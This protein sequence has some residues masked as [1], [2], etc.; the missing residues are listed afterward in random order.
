MYGGPGAS[1]ARI[2]LGKAFGIA[3]ASEGGITSLG[4][5]ACA[6]EHPDCPGK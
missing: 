1:Q 5:H 3:A 2:A 6:R 4:V